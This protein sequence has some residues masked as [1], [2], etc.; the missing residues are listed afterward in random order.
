MVTS[1]IPLIVELSERRVGCL[2]CPVLQSG[3]ITTRCAGRIEGL[4]ERRKRSSGGS[5]VNRN[6]LIPAC[7]WG[8]GFIENEPALIRDL[9]GS[10]LV[11][12]EGDVE[13]SDLGL[14]NDR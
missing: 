8:N 13:W 7:N 10:E 6:N 11:V 1:R 3:G 5:L 14:R 9:F 2:I 4:H 12:R